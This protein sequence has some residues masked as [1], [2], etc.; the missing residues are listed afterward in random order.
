MKKIYLSIA[1]LSITYCAHAQWGYRDST[2]GTNGIVV[3][4]LAAVD[5][6]I[7]T[8]AIQPDGKILAAGNAK[9]LGIEQFAVTR[10]KN[11]GSLDSTFGTNGIVI[12]GNANTIDVV[13][14][15]L[16][17]TD[18][19]IILIGHSVPMPGVEYTDYAVL[20]L[21][22]NGSPDPSFGTNGV[23]TF[24]FTSGVDDY[25]YSGALQ[26]DGKIVVGGYVT[27]GFG[28]DFGVARLN[29]DGT[30]DNTFNGTGKQIIDFSGGADVCFS[31]ALQSDGKILATGYPSNGTVYQFGTVRL[32]TNGTIDNTYGTNGKAT[33]SIGTLED[34]ATASAIQS[35]NKLVVTGYSFS[36][37][38]KTLY[39]TARYNTNGTL[40]NTFGTGGMVTTAVDTNNNW[41]RAV[42]VQS[43]G[44]I[45]V[46]GQV[47][48]GVNF[49]Q[50][51]GL[52]RYNANGTL[53]NTFG[54]GGK[55]ITQISPDISA[56]SALA[57]QGNNKVIAGGIAAFNSQIDFALVRYL[58]GPT[59]GVVNFKEDNNSLLV[60]P[61]PVQSETTLEYTLTEKDH[62]TITIKDVQGRTVSTLVNNQVQD[63]GSHKESLAIPN[64]LPSGNYFVILSSP[65]GQVAVQI[66]K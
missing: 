17:Q 66:T 18:G 12:T 61:N 11:N 52:V 13:Q 36:P 30:L 9:I 26:T 14:K 23:T 3:T 39:A 56:P 8:I 32:N 60:Y 5:E 40:D 35:D 29:T 6:G 44:K 43:D 2:F 59:L 42:V 48:I 65:N 22:A 51:F 64:Y 41:G 62:I 38:M 34:V 21:L 33:T 50:H 28:G 55:V 46:A 15:I 27:S 31:I 57:L 19:K 7:G 20:R 24:F 47:T 53:D 4:D 1:M 54:T 63:A 10:Y 25:A 45:I 49:T 58:T 37:Q 16:V